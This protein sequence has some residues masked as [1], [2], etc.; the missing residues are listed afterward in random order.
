MPGVVWIAVAF[1]IAM[2]VGIAL[3]GLALDFIRAHDSPQ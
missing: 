3:V 2:F 1:L